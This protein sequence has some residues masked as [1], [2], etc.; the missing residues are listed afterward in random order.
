M[1]PLFWRNVFEGVI[2]I[3]MPV[4]LFVTVYIGHMDYTGFLEKCGFGRREVGLLLIGGLV[5]IILG[6]LGLYAVPLFIYENSLL[7][8]DLGGAIIPIV[9]SIYLIN[10]MKLNML[11]LGLFAVV[12]IIVSVVTFYT[13]EF[14]PSLGVVS[15]FPFYLIPSFLAMILALVIY[16]VAYEKVT[17]AVPFAYA[18]ATLGVVIGADIVRIPQVLIGIEQARVEMDLPI[19]AGS[20]GGAGGLDLVF[21]SGLL[22]MVP[23]LILAPRAVKRSRPNVSPSSAF[24]DNLRRRLQGA[25]NALNRRDYESA[26]YSAV[27]AVNMKI[28]DL[29]FKFKINQ[30]PYVVLDMLQVHPYTRNDY[31]LLVNSA[32]SGYKDER[33]AQRGIITARYLIKEFD[34][35]EKKLYATG[36]QRS[37]AFIIDVLIIFGIIMAFFISGAILGIYDLSDILAPQNMIWLVAFILWLWIAQAIY[38]TFFEGLWG[39]TPGKRLMRIKVVNDELK[40]CDFMGAFTRNV[41][42]LLD[43]L[44]L[45][46]AISFIIM[47]MYPR[48]QRIG[49]KVAK[50]VV[51]KA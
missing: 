10:R 4:L 27:F 20:I 22:A 51:L 6:P 45:F 44:L 2:F 34:R 23:L 30:S 47:A 19:A 17:S 14:R 37:V 40:K 5:G 46:Y 24:D 42:R 38:F 26:L 29:G 15:E 33:T 41:I 35:T 32:R 36:I 31:W 11:E 8:I 9:L 28:N 21:L 13:T 49:D 12:I 25:Q 43:T 3:S 7:A 39:Q 16:Y 48:Y 1:D 18:T 50:T